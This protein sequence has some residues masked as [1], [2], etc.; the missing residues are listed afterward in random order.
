V[1]SV[2]HDSVDR[3]VSGGVSV[4]EVGKPDAVVLLLRID[5]YWQRLRY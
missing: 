1:N 4:N 2:A 3:G 5:M